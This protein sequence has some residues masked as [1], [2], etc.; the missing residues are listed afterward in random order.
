[1]GN[2]PIVLKV[3]CYNVAA[4]S[5]NIPSTSS[6]LSFPTLS[7]RSIYICIC[8][9][10]AASNNNDDDDD[11]NKGN[12]FREKRNSG[13]LMSVT[14]FTHLLRSFF[15]GSTVTQIDM[16]IEEQKSEEN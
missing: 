3:S 2:I 16:R 6:R 7:A 10:S 4:H 13:R 1:M 11:D 5:L 12:A 14:P 8:D 15:P 9:K